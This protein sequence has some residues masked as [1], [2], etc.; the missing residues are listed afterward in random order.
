[1]FCTSFRAREISIQV[2]LK[3]LAVMRQLHVES[4]GF[5]QRGLH[6]FAR[7]R[8]LKRDGEP[9]QNELTLNE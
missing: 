7:A 4:L 9:L 8:R 2:H 5:L 1:M 3:K 6:A